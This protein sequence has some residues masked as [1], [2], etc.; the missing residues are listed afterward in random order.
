MNEVRHVSTS[1]R[2]DPADV[3]DFVVEPQNLLQWAAGLDSLDEIEVRFVDRNDLRVAD[4]L[5]T[6]PSGVSTLNPLRVLPNGDGSEVV[7]TLFRV[8][9]VTSEA[10]E[11]DVAAVTR[12]LE[13]LRSLLER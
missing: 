2:R 5:V 4:H 12:D 9:G 7:F 1:I 10:F 6:L 13:T 3:Y 11:A 8:P